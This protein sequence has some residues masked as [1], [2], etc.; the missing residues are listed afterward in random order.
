MTKKITVLL[1]GTVILIGLWWPLEWAG[2]KYSHS[3]DWFPFGPDFLDDFSTYY[4]VFFLSKYFVVIILHYIIYIVC[5]KHYPLAAKVAK[6]VFFFAI[7][8]LIIYLLFSYASIFIGW[9]ILG[10]ILYSLF[11]VKKKWLKF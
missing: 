10:L 5:K 9:T 11:I 6:A 1:I 8:Q 3:L 2:L 4:Y 7:L